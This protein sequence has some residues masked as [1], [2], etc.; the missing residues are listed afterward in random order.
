MLSNILNDINTLLLPVVCFGCNAQLLR[1]ERH[2]CTFCRN[3]IPFTD[4]NFKEENSVD[5]IFYGQTN[6]K[7]ASSFLLFTQI[8]MVKNLIH[9]LKYKNQEQIGVFIGEWYGQIIAENGFLKNIDYVIPVPIHSKKLKKRGYNQV[10]KFGTSIAKHLD[11]KFL[12]TVLIKTA[13]TKTQTKKNRFKRWQQQKNLYELTDPLLLSNK[14][15]LLLD[16]VIT[17]GA[18]ME[19]CAK[20]LQEATGVTI[21]IASMAVVL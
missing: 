19:T 5:R 12:D 9:N 11:A 4:F 1:G 3:Q 2:L 16:D 20:T 6:I 8:G 21:Y 14:K 7:K 15:I 18:T 10:T 17:T 13:N